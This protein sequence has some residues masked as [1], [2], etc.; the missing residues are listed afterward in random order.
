MTLENQID[1]LIIGSGICGL[2]A[3]NRLSEAGFSV[4]VLDKGR[5][6]GGRLATR[7]VS[8]E[9]GLEGVVD[10]GA[11]LFSVQTPVVQ[12][13]ANDWEQAVVIRAWKDDA[14][15]KISKKYIGLH[16]MRGIAKHLTNNLDIRQSERVVGLAQNS[17]WSATTEKGNRYQSAALILTAPLPQAL[18]LLD[19]NQIK[20]EHTTRKQLDQIKYDPCLAVFGIL[21]SSSK[22]EMPGAL[23]IEDGP[24]KWIADHQ[25]RGISEIP[26]YTALMSAKFSQETWDMLESQ[27]IAR[28]LPEIENLLGTNPKTN[29]MHRWKY[30][31]AQNTFSHPFYRQAQPLPLILAGDSFVLGG[32]EGAVLSGMAA[33]EAIIEANS[34]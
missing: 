24:I 13:L 28:V 22:L 14:P 32:V 5:G 25:K 12:S 19:D 3:A 8:Q 9:Q 6:S 4:L 18:I 15:D 1:C 26:T 30:A 11:P 16:G 20:L 2:I 17:H 23:F 33:A 27:L 29:R 7:R 34:D 10:Y 21:E 31:N